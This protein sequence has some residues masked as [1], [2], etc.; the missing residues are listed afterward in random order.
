MHSA[1]R[2]HDARYDVITILI[3]FL[4]EF[5]NAI[6]LFIFIPIFNQLERNVTKDCAY[7]L[8]NKEYCNILAVRKQQE[9]CNHC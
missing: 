1:E 9:D 5:H 7:Q 3:F 2:A 4:N 6:E 8:T